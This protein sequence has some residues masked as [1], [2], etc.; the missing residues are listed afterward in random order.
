MKDPYLA[1]KVDNFLKNIIQIS[2]NFMRDVA[3]M[4]PIILFGE[5]CEI[6]QY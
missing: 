1:I 5:I 6:L 3:S 4:I 2:I